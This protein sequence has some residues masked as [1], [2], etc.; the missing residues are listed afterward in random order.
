MSRYVYAVKFSRYLGYLLSV[1]IVF[2]AFFVLTLFSLFIDFIIGS[3]IRL[4]SKFAD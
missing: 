1:A 4:F 3:A 2:V